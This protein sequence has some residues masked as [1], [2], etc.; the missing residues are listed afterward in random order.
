MLYMLLIA[1][2]EKAAEGK[3]KEELE[4]LLARWFEYDDA[5][6]RQHKTSE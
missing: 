3:T 5:C 1:E 2:N 6:D 4:A